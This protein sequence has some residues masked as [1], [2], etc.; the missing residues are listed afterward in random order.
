MF[1]RCINR[2]LYVKG[3]VRV[4]GQC[5]RK[6]CTQGDLEDLLSLFIVFLDHEAD[7]QHLWLRRDWLLWL[8]IFAFFFFLLHCFFDFRY[9]NW[10]F[11]RVRYVWRWDISLRILFFT[12]FEELFFFILDLFRLRNTFGLYIF[13]YCIKICAWIL[14]RCYMRLLRFFQ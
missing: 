10:S 6:I 8:L 14:H 2:R 3:E 11:Y 5:L 7:V 13:G 12:F 4:G 1:W 9:L